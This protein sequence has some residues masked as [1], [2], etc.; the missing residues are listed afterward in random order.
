MRT[1]RIVA[2]VV[3]VLLLAGSSFARA[4]RAQRPAGEPAADG[5]LVRFRPGVGRQ[6]AR[7]AHARAGAR[8]PRSLPG[9]GLEL[10]DLPTGRDLDRTIRTYEADPRVLYAEPNL[11]RETMA[12]AASV[13]SSA[14]NVERVNAPAAWS[15]VGDEGS[16]VIAV[17]DSGVD[18]AHEDLAD[19]IWLNR[20]ELP[21]PSGPSCDAPPD[22]PW[23]C[24]GDGLFRAS[25][26][27]LEDPPIEDPNANGRLDPEDLRTA[28]RDGQ[29]GYQGNGLTNAH[30]DDVYGWDPHQ[31]DYEPQDT[32]GHGTHVAGTAAAGVG[33][34]RGIDGVCHR[35][36]IMPLRIGDGPFLYLAPEVEA[37]GY[38]ADNGADVANAS[39]GGGE[40]SRSERNA[41]RAAGRDGVLLVAAAG[42]QLADND[43]LPSF[44]A[45]YNL[46][47]VVS[48]AATASNDRYSSF[49]N[50]GHDAVDVAAPGS[51]ILSTSRTG[52][53]VSMSGT[54]M[55]TPHVA[56]AAGL[57]RLLH[58]EAEAVR[59][60]NALMHG[61][62]RVAR[63]LRWDRRLG[64]FTR[65]DGLLDAGASL[66][67]SM[68]NATRLTDGNV[69]GARRLRRVRTGRVTWPQDVNDVFF[70]RLREGN[71]Y[72]IVLRGPAGEDL[73]LWVWKPSA[74]EIW[75][76]EAG[77]GGFGGRCALL[78]ESVSRGSVERVTFRARATGVHHIHVGAYYGS[79]GP[80]RVVVRRV[81]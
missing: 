1:L 61:A 42:N 41:I 52:G 11:A 63:L 39:F 40:W 15:A 67:A 50:I 66:S 29:D 24:D 3:A 81:S 54:S 8:R 71:R 17:L 9:T 65:T 62:E 44:P 73:D 7:T 64:S 49:T 59:V 27:R 43:L 55:A 22:D 36:L 2:S 69:D 80:Y 47:T 45:S 4:G 16:A 79:G 57:V 70:K 74:V 37:L 35:C 68:A 26:Y 46:P 18:V 33:N 77:C 60:K 48:V 20:E 32:N 30:V 34:G 23:D 12:G 72:R 51:S 25:D 10:V 13:S 28:F 56:G 38:A 21:P 75:Q 78:G 14:W 58:P 6:E 53:Y 31:G 76:L 19:S 5:V